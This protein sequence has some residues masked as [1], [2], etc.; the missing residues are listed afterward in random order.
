MGYKMT[1]APENP[2]ADARGTCR[3]HRIVVEAYLGRYL[4]P[5]EVVHHI[6]EI[7]SDNR[8]ENLIVFENSAAHTAYHRRRYSLGDPGVVLWGPSMRS[9]RVQMLRGMAE[10][11]KRELGLTNTQ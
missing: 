6:N 4:K 7:T 9:K 3:T 11:T 2:G 1:H 10:R 5:E 8:I